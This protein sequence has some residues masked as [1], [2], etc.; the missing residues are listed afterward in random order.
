MLGVN[1]GEADSDLALDKKIQEGRGGQE[2]LGVGTRGPEDPEGVNTF[3]LASPA[4]DA[5]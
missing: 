4:K 2:M 5:D 1:P 3:P